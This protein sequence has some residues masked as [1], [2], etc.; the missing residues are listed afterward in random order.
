[1]IFDA[2]THFDPL[3]SR[4]PQGIEYAKSVGVEK[5]IN[6]G[7]H[8]DPRSTHYKEWNNDLYNFGQKYKDLIYP[9]VNVDPMLGQ[10]AVE[11]FRWAIKEKQMVGLK[12][13]PDFQ[14]FK[15]KNKEAFDLFEEAEKLNVPVFICSCLS[16]VYATPST[17]GVVAMNF[18][19]LK[20]VLSH[21]G[22][23]NF[24]SDAIRVAKRFKN[25][26]LLSCANPL[27]GLREM[28]KEIG[29]D[30]IMFGTDFP[31]GYPHVLKYELAKVNLLEISKAEKEKILWRNISRLI[32]LE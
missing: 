23:T 18:P 12:L 29:A 24:W 31:Y 14:S 7:F 5:I 22:S 32:N 20:I 25:I 10:E 21:A 17:V 8:Y 3:D 4:N 26:T 15:I 2:H 27:R 19:N 1:M 11:I 9:V 28:V 6:L 13:I 30:R 16:P